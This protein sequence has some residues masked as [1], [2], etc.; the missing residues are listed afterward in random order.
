MKIAT[1]TN[2]KEDI[3]NL[4]EIA[5]ET[6]DLISEMQTAFI[7]NN[8]KPIEGYK[9]KINDQCETA[10][11][12]TI[13]IRDT[14]QNNEEMKAYIKVSEHLMKIWSNLGKLFDLIDKKNSQKVLF[15]DKAVNETTYLLQRLI[16][17]L[18]PSS[19]IILAR[20]KFLSTYIKESQKSLEKNATDYATLHE[21]RLI[22]GECVPDASSIYVSMLDAIK[23]IA[24]NTKEIAITLE[25]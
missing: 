2:V 6:G 24:W 16:E 7:Y 22:T 1:K 8:S 12:L 10:M 17:I 4:Y 25:K 21:D 11:R 20:N 5:S 9:Q 13:S 15:S 14:A 18:R 23:S 3:T 19:D